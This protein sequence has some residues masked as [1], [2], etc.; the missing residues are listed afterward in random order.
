ME[1]D[2]APVPMTPDH[3]EE[4]IRVWTAMHDDTEAYEN[5]PFWKGVSTRAPSVLKTCYLRANCVERLRLSVVMPRM[6][7][8]SREQGR[9]SWPTATCVA[10]GRM[11]A[12][13][14]MATTC[15]APFSGSLSYH[16][17]CHPTIACHG[18]LSC[19]SRSWRGL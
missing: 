16:D 8:H 6:T 9:W 11:S 10:S 13:I 1:G 4:F 2:V 14:S 17:Q 5:E 12:R 3:T 18:H 15:F 7:F 19:H